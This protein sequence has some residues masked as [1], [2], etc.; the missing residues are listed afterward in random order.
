M[1][2]TVLCQFTQ[3]I[4]FSRHTRLSAGVTQCAMFSEKQITATCLIT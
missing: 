3:V 2:V 1:Y 4:K